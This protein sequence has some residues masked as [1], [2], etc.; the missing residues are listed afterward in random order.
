MNHTAQQ[1]L[2]IYETSSQQWAT[3]LQSILSGAVPSE[4]ICCYDI[5]TVSCKGENI[6]VLGEYTCK[7][8]VLSKNLLRKLCQVRRFFLARV[9]SPASSVVVLLCGV[10]SLKPLLDLVPLN[11]EQCLQISSEQDPKEYLTAVMDIV[12][13][14]VSSP[15]SNAR[16]LLRKASGE[17]QNMSLRQSSTS[18][19]LLSTIALVPSR[20]PCGSSAE[21]FLLL[22]NESAANVTEVQFS[23]DNLKVKVKPTQWSDSVI[24][25]SAPDFPA[26]IVKVTV[27]SNGVALNKTELSY[28]SSLE[29]MNRLLSSMADPVQFMCQALRVPSTEKL[30]QM[31]SSMLLRRMPRGGFQ[32]LQR[33]SK[34]ER[35]SH[36]SEVH[37]ML[38]FAAQY[39]LKSLSSVLLQCPC[40]ERA[41]LTANR[42]GHTPSDIAMHHGHTELHVLLKQTPKMMD[43][44]DDSVYETMCTTGS[45]STENSQK[46]QREE[47]E[48][49][50]EDPYAA[51]ELSDVYDTMENAK[52][53]VSISNRPP[54]PTPRPQNTED[55]TSYITKVLQIQKNRG[56]TELYSILTKQGQGQQSPASS[57]YDTFVAASAPGFHQRVRAGSL[58]TE[59]AKDPIND[60]QRVQ[61]GAIQQARHLTPRQ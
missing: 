58:P 61:K 17:E 15:V 37:T 38:H 1:V 4:S 48:G 46:E 49:E 24:S 54:A 52:L 42:H 36:N 10:D 47:E 41:V 51:F 56:N 16:P 43:P 27:L 50:E 5:T 39:G 22:K 3:Y 9:L 19:N 57:L 34:P 23:K 11:G 21:V 18:Y 29:E 45:A 44:G 55:R 6:L 59:N 40:A 35:E 7:L 14:G 25:F 30:D 53:E 20:V 32:G 2:I 60:G 33:E 8:L 12:N 28:Y 13:K 26:G 31:L